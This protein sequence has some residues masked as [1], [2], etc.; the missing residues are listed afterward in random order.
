MRACA[1]G[2]DRWE[3]KSAGVKGGLRFCLCLACCTFDPLS[4]SL[5]LSHSL[6]H[7]HTHARMGG[8]GG[9]ARALRLWQGSLHRCPRH[10]VRL[11]R[12]GTA[13][14]C[15]ARARACGRLSCWVVEGQ[16]RTRQGRNSKEKIRSQSRSS[17]ASTRKH[18]HDLARP[19][20]TRVPNTCA[21]P[22]Q[23][24][25]SN[26]VS[27]RS[28]TPPNARPWHHHVVWAG[29]QQDA[30]EYRKPLQS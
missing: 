21:S 24:L 12:H 9:G 6:T 28:K 19:P 11:R 30:T 7:T 4:L 14:A 1:Q 25:H 26:G 29:V 16:G 27:G 2:V 22:A 13:C 3:T 5:L 17:H 10:K 18:R 15:H 20:P 23:H 8:G